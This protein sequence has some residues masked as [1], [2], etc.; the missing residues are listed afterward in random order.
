MNKLTKVAV[1]IGAALTAFGAHAQSNNP[2]PNVTVYGIVDAYVQSLRGDTTLHRVQSGGLNS[3]RFGLRGIEDL[4]GGLR[5]FYTL[6]AGIN[7]DDG[8]S[9]QGGVLFGRQALVGLGSAQFGQVSLGR[10]Y[11]SIYVAT[12]ADFS[13]FSNSGA[14][15]NTS[16][17]GGFAGGYEPVRGASLT[18]APPG[19]GATG[20]GGPARVNNS[21][22]YESPTFAGLRVGALYGA[23]EVADNTSGQRLIDL[24]ARYSASIV[25]VLASRVSDK[26][27][28]GT[29]TDATTTT[30][31]AAFAFAEGHV[32][33]GFM[34]VDDGRP[35]NEDGRG[36]WLGGDYRINRHLVRAQYIVNDPRT[37]HDTR[38][39]AFGVGYEYDLSKRTALYGSLTRFANQANAGSGGLGRW[40]AAIPTGLTSASSNDLTELAA[41]IRHTF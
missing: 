15:P 19:A 30:L 11:S 7:V 13:A 39:Q 5:A 12:S 8:S 35:A 10:Q 14:G 21:V 16:L 27:V 34:N 6:E 9:A 17:I 40:T 4:G 31:A 36:Y 24:F 26:A 23:G 41:G 32:Y 37:G 38:T 28:G 29:G 25:D 2:S 18:G 20:N 22:R 33:A 3:S 1:A